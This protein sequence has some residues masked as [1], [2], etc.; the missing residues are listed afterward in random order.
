MQFAH[1]RFQHGGFT[2]AVGA[3]DSQL[4]AHFQQQADVFKQRAVIEAFGHGLHFQRVAEQFLVLLEADKRVLTAGGF[5]LFQFD[6]VNLAGA[7]GRLTGFR[8]VGAKAAHKRL[9]V[10]NLGFFLGVVRQQTLA[11]LGRRGH[12]FVVVA[13]INAQL[14]VIE[15][16]HV[17]ADHVQ[18]VTVVRNDNHGAV[19]IVQRLLQPANGVDV[20]VVRRFVEQQDIRV[21]EQR[22]RQQHTQLPARSDFAHRAVV[23]LQR[24]ADA[25]QQLTRAGFRA[26]AVHFAI[27]HFEIGHFIAV[28]FAHLRQTVDAVALLLHFPQFAVPHDYG[29]QHGILFKRELILTQLTDAFVRVER[30]VARARL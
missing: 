18:E 23:L 9:Q 27:F 22:L 25:Q 5:H 19:A 28:L 21:R 11:R 10:R 29:V 8:G 16:R 1:Q 13:R 12:V 3:E 20:Q 14:A 6:F 4:L 17:G 24:N 7:G 30:N 15:I 26:V 2:H